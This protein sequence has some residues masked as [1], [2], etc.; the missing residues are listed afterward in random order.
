MVE[1]YRQR[2]QSEEQEN[3]G[4]LRAAGWWVWEAASQGG[5]DLKGQLGAQGKQSSSWRGQ[6]FL[7]KGLLIDWG[8]G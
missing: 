2:G 3:A 6:R 5:E 1:W 4:D 8:W 7:M